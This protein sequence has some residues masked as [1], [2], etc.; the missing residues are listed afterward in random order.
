MTSPRK[1]KIAIPLVAVGFAPLGAPA[2]AQGATLAGGLSLPSLP[3]PTL[4]VLP[5]APLPALPIPT[6]PGHGQV[7][8]PPPPPAQIPSPPPPAHVPPAPLPRTHVPPPPPR[9]Q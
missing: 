2:Q 3:N 1:A 9:T 7:Q 4:P 6:P 8:S 5:P